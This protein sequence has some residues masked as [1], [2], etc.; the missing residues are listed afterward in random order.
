M[1]V[2]VR[3]PEC[4]GA[5]QVDPAAL[6]QLVICPR[7]SG[8]FLAVQEPPVSPPRAAPVS[9][10]PERR[11]PRRRNR[12]EPIAPPPSE[13]PATPADPHDHLHDGGLPAS[14]LIGLALLPF[15]IPLLWL[16]AP[17]AVGQ[18]PALSLAAPAALAVTA[19][20]LS[21]AVIYTI[22]WTPATRVKGVLMLVGLAYF[23]GFS[24][25]FLKKDMVDRVKRTFDPTWHEFRPPGQ[26]YKVKLP[27]KPPMPKEG[28]QPLGW[29]MSC[30]G[31]SQPSL[32]GETHY[33]VGAGADQNAATE[34]DAWFKEVERR[35]RS[36]N[37]PLAAE[38][39]SIPYEGS[40]G[41][42]WVLTPQQGVT[43]IVRVYRVKKRVYYLAVEGLD[44]R[45]D[46]D[47][48]TKFLD[49]FAVLT[50]E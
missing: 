50:K 42:Q 20:A 48:A 40:P 8:P 39:E 37:I 46:D 43:R 29:P 11:A 22:D 45:S 6:D 41:R 12:A 26:N 1:S 21:L 9:P 38:V 36:D 3:C 19:S 4:R 15:V 7:C 25:Y 34:E 17:L 32:I 13:Q 14:V 18:P 31:T 28:Y 16:V 5:A 49:S 24:L 47:E 33:W 23:A 2:V 44:M 30:Y 35:L 10:P 27:G